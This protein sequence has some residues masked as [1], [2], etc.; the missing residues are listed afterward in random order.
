MPTV[1]HG[2]GLLQ[3]HHPAAGYRNFYLLASVQWAYETAAASWTHVTRCRLGEHRRPSR[4]KNTIVR[5]AACNSV[6]VLLEPHFR[7]PATT[8]STTTNRIRLAGTLRGAVSVR[9]SAACTNG[10]S[11][12]PPK[13]HIAWAIGVLPPRSD[14]DSPQHRTGIAVYPSRRAL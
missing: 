8:V 2:R 1:S 13:S 12:L 7:E 9:S 10:R 14:D 6:Q 3:S 5:S 11:C 4:D